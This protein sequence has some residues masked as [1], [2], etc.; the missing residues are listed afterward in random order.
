M[1]KEVL[2]EVKITTISGALTG[3]VM[4]LIM[5][6]FFGLSLGNSII[7]F[8]SLLIAGAFTGLLGIF[9]VDNIFRDNAFICAIT[10]G[11]MLLI[12]VSSANII[13]IFGSF[14]LMYAIYHLIKYLFY[15]DIPR[16]F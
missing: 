15:K 12:R 2:E 7:L 13:F 4:S 8:F 14:S 10:L 5:F 16:F 1:K 6:L 9:K 3:L 11:L